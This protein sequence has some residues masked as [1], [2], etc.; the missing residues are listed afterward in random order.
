MTNESKV[1]KIRAQYA[2]ATKEQTDI[3]KLRELDKQVKRPV[4]VFSYALGTASAL[5]LGTGMTMAMA[6]I[7]GGM[8]AGVA[9]GCAGIAGAG[10]NYPLHISE[11]LLEKI[12]NS[13]FLFLLFYLFV[14]ILS[15]ISIIFFE[16]FF[17]LFSMSFS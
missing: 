13:H 14:K 10:A 7:P 17:F 9:I 12:D 5:I 4:K 16:Y 15:D 2:E 11:S 8:A 1:N 6:L 3:E